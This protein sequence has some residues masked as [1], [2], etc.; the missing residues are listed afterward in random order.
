MKRFAVV[1][2]GCGV[3]DGAEIHE[4]VLTLLAIERAGAS[5]QCFAPDILQHHVIDHVTGSEMPEKRNVLTES[6]R[7]ARG[8]ILPLSKFR[9]AEYDGLI[10]P[11]GFGAAKNL[12]DW[13][14]LG[15][16]CTVNPDVERV[17]REM[18][19]AGKPIGAMCIAPVILAKL[20]RGTNLTTGDDAASGKF[21][22]N[23]G[24]LYVRTTHGEVIADRTLKIFTTPCYM[25]DASILQI[26]EGTENIVREMMAVL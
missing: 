9:A 3:F 16:S 21:I 19:A 22:E 7:I 12:C 20:F 25:L 6:A 13:A 4:S 2:S 23:T 18:Q 17:I 8:Q 5:W 11:G 10:F 1:L 15:D 26:A 14:F 24:N